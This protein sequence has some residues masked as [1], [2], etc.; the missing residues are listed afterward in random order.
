[1]KPWMIVLSSAIVAIAAAAGAALPELSLTA[2]SGIA[3]GFKALVPMLVVTVLAAYALCAILLTAA[4]LVGGCVLL[5]YRLARIPPHRGPDHP[6]WTA[7]F[8]ASGLRRLAPDL[9]VFP[10]RPGGADRIVAVRS[11]F[12]PEDARREM[13]RLYHLWAARTHFYSALIVLAAAA[14][15]GLAQ[16]HGALP[17]PFGPVPTVPAALILVGLVLLGVLG[18]LAVDVAVEP[19]VGLLSRLPTEP[20]DIALLRRAVELLEIG[21]STQ[22]VEDDSALAAALQMPERV[23]GVFED[24]RRALFAAIER[25]SA[26][27]DGLAST[28]RSAIERL[29]AAVRDGEWRAPAA[30]TAIPAAAEL[31]RLQDAIVALTAAVERAPT[32]APGPLAVARVAGSDFPVAGREADPQFA[33]E[34]KKLLAEIGTVP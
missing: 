27:T 31:S 32:L 4:S 9:A 7:A 5:R 10:L 21:P 8:E 24:G 2:H 26:T 28:T 3:P 17:D 11:R 20:V 30:E 18:R 22:L 16:Q 23:V 15:L 34:L 6:D 13:A 25:L 19:L 29:E 14:A 33:D 1:M 12:H